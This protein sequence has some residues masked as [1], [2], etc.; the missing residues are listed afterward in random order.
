MFLGTG[1]GRHVIANQTRQTGGFVIFTGASQIVCDPGPGHIV[2]A[3]RNKIVPKETNIIFVSHEHIDHCND[4]AVLIDAITEGKRH[5]KG[6]FIAPKTVHTHTIHPYYHDAGK[7]VIHPEETNAW[8]STKLHFDFYP[9]DH[10]GG[11][12][13]F[14]LQTTSTIIGYIA[15]TNYFPE[16]SEH[17]SSADVLIINMTSP[18]NVRFPGHLNTDD[19]LS[20]LTAMEKKPQAILITHLGLDMDR[21]TA[22]KEADHIQ[23]TTGIK[24]IVALDN[25]IFDCTTTTWQT[26]NSETK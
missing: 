26:K 8:E 23:K 20:I 14:M 16:L 19:A 10:P 4:F 7:T 3:I 13:G 2:H 22:R 15:D 1:G 11:A 5:K 25:H 12:Y 24:T 9:L 17:Y 18:R 6:V 21:D